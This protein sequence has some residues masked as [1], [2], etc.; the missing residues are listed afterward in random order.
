MDPDEFVIRTALWTGKLCAFIFLHT[1]YLSRIMSLC[2]HADRVFV[3][4]R[5]C[6]VIIP[7]VSRGRL[8]RRSEHAAIGSGVQVASTYGHM[9]LVIPND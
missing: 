9:I 1:Y 7:T 2:T 6:P 4:N 8:I 3:L 5:L